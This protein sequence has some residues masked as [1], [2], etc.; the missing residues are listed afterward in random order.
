MPPL[1]PDDERYTQG[2][3]YALSADGLFLVGGAVAVYTA[4]SLLSEPGPPST[5]ES[6]PRELFPGLSVAPALAPGYGGVAAEMKF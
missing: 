3:I 4:L 6:A 2:K 1:A 5:S